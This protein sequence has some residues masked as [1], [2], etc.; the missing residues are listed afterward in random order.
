MTEEQDGYTAFQLMAVQIDFSACGKTR[1]EV[2]RMLKDRGIG[3]EVHDIPLY[4]H[5]V[6]KYLTEEEEFSETE[7]FY[8][9]TLCLP[10][11]YDLTDEDVQRV[12]RELKEVLFIS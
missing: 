2:M 11:Y 8:Q 9:Q 5:P 3:T 10:L 1:L 12:C 4:H 7:A 6:F